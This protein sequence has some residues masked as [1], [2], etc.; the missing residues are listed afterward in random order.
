MASS[1]RMWSG[2]KNQAADE[3]SKLGSSRAQ[4]PHIVFVQDLVKSSIK[5]EVDQVVEKPLD[6]P[7]VATVPPPSTTESSRQHL[8]YLRPPTLTIGEYLL[9]SF[10]RIGPVMLIEQRMS[11]LCAIVSSTYWSMVS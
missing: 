5:E 2:I 3:L 1:T 6:Q 8:Q 10:C 7:L 4:V 9:S 11:G